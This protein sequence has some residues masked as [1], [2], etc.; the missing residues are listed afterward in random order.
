MWA[1]LAA[2]GAAFAAAVIP[3]LKE[4]LGEFFTQ[5]APAMLAAF[6]IVAKN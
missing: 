2:A 5:H 6:T 4:L 3:G 1:G